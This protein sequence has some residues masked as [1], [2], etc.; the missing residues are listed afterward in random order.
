MNKSFSTVIGFVSHIFLW[1]FKEFIREDGVRL[2]VQARLYDYETVW[3][4]YQ[5]VVLPN[6]LQPQIL[7][8]KSNLTQIEGS[9][10]FTVVNVVLKTQMTQ[11]YAPNAEHPFTRLVSAIREANGNTTRE[12]RENALAYQTAA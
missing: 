2:Y 10:W 5:T 4:L 7:K 3:I 8:T 11:R 1:I 6:F 9:F 12:Y